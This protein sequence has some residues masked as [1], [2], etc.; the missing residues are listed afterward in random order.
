MQSEA[1]SDSAPLR[2][3]SKLER[4]KATAKQAGKALDGT[5]SCTPVF[6]YLQLP[7]AQQVLCKDIDDVEVENLSTTLP[8]SKSKFRL[9][10]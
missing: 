8:R 10:M 1:K 9:K 3:V 5:G 6:I 4:N 7:L 2:F